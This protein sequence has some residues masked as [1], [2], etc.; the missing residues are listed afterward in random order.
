M[1][2]AAKII[3]FFKSIM[4]FFSKLFAL[5]GICCLSFVIGRQ[6]EKYKQTNNIDEVNDSI[7]VNDNDDVNENIITTNDYV[8]VNDEIKENAINETEHI[9]SNDTTNE[10]AIEKTE[11]IDYDLK[12]PDYNNREDVEDYID[13]RNNFREKNFYYLTE[14]IPFFNDTYVVINSDN[15]IGE[16]FVKNQYVESINFETDLNTNLDIQKYFLGKYSKNGYSVFIGRYGECMCQYDGF[17]GVL[18][19]HIGKKIITFHLFDKKYPINEYDFKMS[20][21]KMGCIDRSG[22]DFFSK[23]DS[24]KH[25]EWIYSKDNFF[26][27]S[28]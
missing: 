14:I 24:T 8:A 11:Y 12:V 1:M 13:P 10:S 3:V 27:T 17:W 22:I 16:M 21:D 23:K 6:Y 15:K 5:F 9:I 2:F 4:K 20:Y 18:D 28:F 7:V 19:I 25:R 26:F